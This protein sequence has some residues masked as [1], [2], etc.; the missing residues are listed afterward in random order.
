MSTAAPPGSRSTNALAVQDSLT[1][2]L[3]LAGVHLR[4]NLKATLREPQALFFLVAFPVLFLIIFGAVFTW[5]VDEASGVQGR[6]Y[7]SAGILAS[8]MFGT[9]FMNLAIGIVSQREEGWLKR[10]GGAPVPKMSYF[11]AQIGAAFTITVAQTIVMVALGIAAFGFQTPDA[12]QWLTLI[13]VLLLGVASG[14][15]MGIAITRIIPSVRA[16][17]AVVN[18]PYILLQ[19]ISGVFFPFHNLP[20]ALQIIAS[21]FPLRWLAQGLRSVFL[22]DDFRFVEA[23]GSW[24]LHWVAVGLGVWI[25]VGLA[26]AVRTFRWDQSG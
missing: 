19:F 5:D 23:S 16:A 7:V 13:W 26:L 11:L 12:G 3:R 8:S 1:R 2:T 15:A 25:V 18:L 24:D 22:P 6:Q 17:P 20:D 9:S 21:V 4:L 14:C 10:L